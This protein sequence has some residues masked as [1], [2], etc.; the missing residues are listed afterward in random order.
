[1]DPKLAY[2]PYWLLNMATDAA[3]YHCMKTVREAAKHVV[4][5]G[6][7]YKKRIDQKTDVYG[8]ITQRV[9]AHFAKQ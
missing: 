6:S 7:E 9:N 3:A 4:T 5:Q 2:T 8:D 1:M